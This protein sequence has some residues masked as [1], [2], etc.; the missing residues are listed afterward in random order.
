MPQKAAMRQW[1]LQTR[2]RRLQKVTKARKSRRLAHLISSMPASTV[3]E[4]NLT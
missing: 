3:K 1:K 2:G 4:R